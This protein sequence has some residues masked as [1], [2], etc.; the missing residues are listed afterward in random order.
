M[1]KLVLYLLDTHVRYSTHE[2]LMLHACGKRSSIYTSMQVPS[3]FYLAQKFRGGNM[4]EVEVMGRLGG[5]RGWVRE[6][7]VP[8]PA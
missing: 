4:G 2:N 8:P 3:G 7:D 1:F 6:G 5:P